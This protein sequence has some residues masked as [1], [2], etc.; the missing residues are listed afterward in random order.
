MWQSPTLN[1]GFPLGLCE[2]T[3]VGLLTLAQCC[4]P[5]P[6]V[7]SILVFAGDLR[8]ACTSPTLPSVPLQMRHPLSQMCTNPHPQCPS[9]PGFPEQPRFQVTGMSPSCLGPGGALSLHHRAAGRG[10]GRQHK[11]PCRDCPGFSLSLK[12]DFD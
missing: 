3:Q 10:G 9:G 11:A 7:G 2:G 12:P 4:P 6:L 5:C 1:S 8:F